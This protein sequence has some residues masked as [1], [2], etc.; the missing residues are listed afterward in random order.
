MGLQKGGAN[1]NDVEEEEASLDSSLSMNTPTTNVPT[2][3]MPAVNGWSNMNSQNSNSPYTNSPNQSGGSSGTGGYS[4]VLSNENGKYF[5]GITRGP[6]P[7]PQT[8]GDHKQLIQSYP[9]GHSD[10]RPYN[11]DNANFLEPVPY[12]RHCM[13]GGKRQSRRKKN[14]RSRNRR[15]H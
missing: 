2:T 15:H 14:R 1:L 9:A 5:D 6:C 8:G 7:I 3:N 4:M 10:T 13:G 12:G 11:S